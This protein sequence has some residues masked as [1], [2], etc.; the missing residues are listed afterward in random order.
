MVR[1]GAL[2]AVLL[3]AC[4]GGVRGEKTPTDG[5]GGDMGGGAGGNESVDRVDGSTIRRDGERSEPLPTTVCPAQAPQEGS[6]CD[7]E[8]VSCSFGDDPRWECRAIYHCRASSWEWVAPGD[9][10]DTPPELC[11]SA[12]PESGHACAPA[13][14]E[15][16]VNPVACMYGERRCECYSCATHLL[17]HPVPCEHWN[18]WG[19]PEDLDCPAAA[20]NAGDGCLFA[21]QGKVCEYGDPCTRSGVSFLCRNRVWEVGEGTACP[22]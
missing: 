8:G 22:Q 1:R 6:A 21:A 9:C 12:P 16:F 11:P 14:G 10:L 2:V 5:R 7:A 20:P 19:A 4:G 17:S 15:P 3:S 18:C 13:R